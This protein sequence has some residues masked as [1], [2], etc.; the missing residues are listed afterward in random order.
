MEVE[1]F[2]HRQLAPTVGPSSRSIGEFE[3]PFIAKIRFWRFLPQTRS[4]RLNSLISALS[5]IETDCGSVLLSPTR[6]L[7]CSYFCVPGTRA[8]SEAKSRTSFF[9]SESA[10]EKISLCSSCTIPRQS[11]A[12]ALHVRPEIGFGVNQLHDTKDCLKISRFIAGRTQSYQEA[13]RSSLH[14]LQ[15]CTRAR[16]LVTWPQRLY[17]DYAVRRRDVV[18]W[19]YDYLD[20]LPRL[21]STRKLVEDGPRGINN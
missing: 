11:T 5:D 19:A 14:T 12:A 9:F 3:G 18:F 17:I 13:T 2:K 4:I 15:R 6:S 16:L 20:Y 7:P 10:A 21:V 8:K 1:R